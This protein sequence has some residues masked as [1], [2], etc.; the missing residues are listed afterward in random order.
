[1]YLKVKKLTVKRSFITVEVKLRGLYLLKWVRAWPF[2]EQQNN[3]W[4]YLGKKLLTVLLADFDS[5]L[6]LNY[7]S[8]KDF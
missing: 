3:E 2:N 5:C 6:I 1:M 7:K 4:E 8:S